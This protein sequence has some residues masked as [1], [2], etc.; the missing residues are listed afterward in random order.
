MGAGTGSEQANRHEEPGVSTGTSLTDG[1]EV[2]LDPED[3][4]TLGQLIEAGAVSFPPD[5]AEELMTGYRILRASKYEPPEGSETEVELRGSGEASGIELPLDDLD[6]GGVTARQIVLAE[7]VDGDEQLAEDG[8]TVEPG[9][10]ASR[11]PAQ[12]G[13]DGPAQAIQPTVLEVP[14]AQETH[15]L[16]QAVD[17]LAD[18]IEAAGELAAAA[19]PTSQ[20]IP[21]DGRTNGA[22][23]LD[24][25]MIGLGL[26]VS[27]MLVIA[28]AFVA[29]PVFA[30]LGLALLVMCVFQA[31]PYLAESVDEGGEL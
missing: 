15:E 18:R 30:I 23:A 29:D 31:V 2:E 27:T 22:L 28:A 10:D 26:G 4:W 14:G 24:W 5:V 17:R 9:V 13:N 19:T 20:A 8:A 6:E 11:P 25:A 21:T 12:E 1:L 7:V 3:V 16:A